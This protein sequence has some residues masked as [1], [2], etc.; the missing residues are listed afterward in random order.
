MEAIAKEGRGVVVLIRESNSG[1]I[2]AR[3]DK[4]NGQGT[5]GQ[6]RLIDYGIGA[7]ILLDLGV[8]QMTL[9]SNT[10]R[11]IVGLE[12]YGL[13]VTGHRSLE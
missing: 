2:S 8:R 1:D 4:Q 12:G 13:T 3:V 7:Q 11:K 9:L 6:Q 5:A 10:P